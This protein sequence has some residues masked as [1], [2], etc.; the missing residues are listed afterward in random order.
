VLGGTWAGAG[1][2]AGEVVDL[3]K[4][5]KMKF[6]F[7]IQ[8]LI[9][10]VFFTRF[11]LSKSL[12]LSPTRFSLSRQGRGKEKQLG[13]LLSS[14][15][16]DASRASPLIKQKSNKTKHFSL[17]FSLSLLSS[18]SNSP[19]SLLYLPACRAFTSRFT[20]VS[21]CAHS[22]QSEAASAC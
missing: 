3:L 17:F 10:R 18:L 5:K 7:V 16:S 9:F 19:L 21:H 8:L 4:K 20:A 15:C 12:S 13:Q 14:C 22:S 11:S 6:F 2:G 1:A